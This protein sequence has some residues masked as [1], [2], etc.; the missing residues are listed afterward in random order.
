MKTTLPLYVFASYITAMGNVQI[1]Y[2]YAD[3]LNGNDNCIWFISINGIAVDYG[4]VR[5]VVLKI[6]PL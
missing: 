3:A 5:L 4:L 2:P 6:E 1:R